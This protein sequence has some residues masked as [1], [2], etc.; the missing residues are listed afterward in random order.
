MITT[1]RQV[2]QHGRAFVTTN[3]TSRFKRTCAYVKQTSMSCF[4]VTYC[5]HRSCND[6]AD[7]APNTINR[8]RCNLVFLG[9][10]AATP[11]N[12]NAIR[13]KLVIALSLITLLTPVVSAV[14]GAFMHSCMRSYLISITVCTF[15]ITTIRIAAPPRWPTITPPM[16]QVGRF[17]G[18]WTFLLRDGSLLR[19]EHH[20]Q[21]VRA[22]EQ[23]HVAQSLNMETQIY[24]TYL[25]D[26]LESSDRTGAL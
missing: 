16:R 15:L 1:I 24:L 20:A 22:R 4:L 5:A 23:T 3:P 10:N 17:S 19:R 18:F 26:P 25:R 14:F 9:I 6:L 11:K 2:F 8:D 7:M 13:I 21:T 12:D